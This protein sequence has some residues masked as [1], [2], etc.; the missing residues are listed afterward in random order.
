MT[1][2]ATPAD[3]LRAAVRRIVADALDRPL[4]EVTPSSSLID[5]LGAESIDFLDIQFR[6][7]SALEVELGEEELYGGRLDFADPAV[8]T[9][10]RLTAE[11]RAELER[12]QPDF[13][14]HRF[15]EAIRSADL[16]RLITP[17]SI[18]AA[19]VDTLE[20]QAGAAAEAGSRDEEA[21]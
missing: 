6:L 10:G 2:P 1:N 7:E 15:P 4:S 14:W 19:L 12:L 20:A 21:R 3:E 9:D 17:D 5:D 13:A 8:M 11:A 16:P 18:A